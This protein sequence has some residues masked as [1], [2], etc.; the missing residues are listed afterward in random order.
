[1]STGNISIGLLAAEALLER[2]GLR[3]AYADTEIK[4]EQRTADGTLVSDL[5]AVKRHFEIGYVP[6]TTG[7][8]LDVLLALYDLH[9][10]L[11]L[12]I[13]NEDDTTGSYTVVMRPLSVARE[14]VRDNWL[15][16][17]AKLILD[18]V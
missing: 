11:S 7:T 14:V 1:M 3:F 4:S 2:K 9:A 5:R 18:E 17:G 13:N 16:S 8:N 6:M 15:W 12:L 10:E